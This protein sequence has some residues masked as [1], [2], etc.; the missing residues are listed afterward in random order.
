MEGSIMSRT[1]RN[2][3]TGLGAMT[4][5]LGISA[6]AGAQT[7]PTQRITFIVGFAAGGFTDVVARAVG[8]HVSKKLGQPVV[9]ENRGGAASNIAARLVAGA[10]PDGYTVL[11]STTALA[12]NATAHRKIDYSLL[13]DLVPVA[14][15][16][17]APETFGAKPGGAK[18]LK[19]FID[20]AKSS[21]GANFGSAGAG[22]GSHLTWFGF[23]KSNADVNVVHV[24]FQGAAPAQQAVLGG[25]V[26]ALAATASGAVVA[27]LSDGG[28]M[29]CLAVAAAKRYHL[30]PNCP[31][32]TE[33]GF[34]GIE[35][36]SWVG[37]WVP[38]GT[39]ANVID[40]LNGAI[41]AIT[42]D[43][44]AA[45]NLKRNGDLTG[46]DAKQADAFVRGEVASWGERVKAA[47]AQVD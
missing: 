23:F 26:D 9:V 17:R 32:L 46:F 4:I 22:T 3:V 37:F 45:D 41:N 12:I 18:T 6:G 10:K 7:Y 43:Q 24:P 30:L 5:A 25:Q 20:Q 34:P 39:P 16:V 8:E 1:A 33:V 28:K 14:I 21:G 40:A 38:K 15:A 13:D 47:G 29:T 2:I 35:G 31:T 27:Q 19:E 11:V 42:E 36:S 44:K